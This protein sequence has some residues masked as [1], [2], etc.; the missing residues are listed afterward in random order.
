M[1]FVPLGQEALSWDGFQGRE[2]SLSNES[3]NVGRLL[4]L[5]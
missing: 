1:V 2:L 3:S 5:R 4:N